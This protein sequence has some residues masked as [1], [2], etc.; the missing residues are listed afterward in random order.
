MLQPWLQ[1]LES[2]EAITRS[3]D[4]R[5]LRLTGIRDGTSNTFMI[6]EDIPEL[7]QHCGWPNA[8]YAN[9]TCAIPPNVNVS[10]VASRAARP[11][12]VMAL[13]PRH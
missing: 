3:D 11:S 8:N 9:G 12:R 4:A 5:K 6:G 7:N 10:P 1:D 2:L 13:P